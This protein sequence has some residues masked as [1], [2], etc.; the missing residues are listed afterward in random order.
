MSTAFA[1]GR[2]DGHVLEDE[3]DVGQRFHNPYER[4]KLDAEMALKRAAVAS[5]IDVRV[6][7][8]SIVVG[9]AP[10]T[11]G[12]VPSNLFFAVVRLLARVAAL[13]TG[14]SRALRLP[15]APAAPFNAVPVEYVVDAAVAL[16]E[17][18]EAAHGTFHVVT[19]ESPTQEAVLAMISQA[20][21]L[22][23]ARIVEA[24][25][26]ADDASPFE[27]RLARMLGPY[28]E[29][30]AQDVRFDDRR[31]RSVLDAAGVPRATLDVDAVQRL[32]GLA[33]AGETVAP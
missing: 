22:E 30:L 7:R 28:A 31:A 10:A 2:R 9:E 11:A 23:G 3:D 13:G 32:V 21:G 1:C 6:L 8:P 5:G 16:A 15:G 27:G 25:Q 19:S 12:G 14:A 18:P 26:M 33:L 24:Q 17:G 29:Y 20:L 4:A